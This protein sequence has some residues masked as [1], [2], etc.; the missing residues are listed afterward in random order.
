MRLRRETGAATDSRRRMRYLAQ[1]VLFPLLAGVDV[2]F[3]RVIVAC[4]RQV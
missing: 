2:H 3:D 4:F 1:S